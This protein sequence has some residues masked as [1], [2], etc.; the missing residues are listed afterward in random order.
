MFSTGQRIGGKYEIERVLGEGGM[1]VVVAA[2]HTGLG[3]RV[4]LKFLKPELLSHEVIV[5]RFKREARAASRIESD[6][7]ARVMDV[8]TTP[9]GV[10]FMVME[11]LEG[12]D[13]SAVRRR[14]APLDVGDAARVIMDACEAI[15]EAHRLGIVHRDIKPANIFLARRADGRTRVKVLDFGISKMTGDGEM[16]V[17]KTSSFMGSAEYM[18]PEQMLGTRDV[19]ARTDVWALGVTL[20]ELVTASVPF[21]ADS[22]PRVC[23][24]VLA[25]APVV[26]SSVRPSIPPALDAIILRCLEKE[27]ENRYAS[28]AE[29][30]AALAPFAGGVRASFVPDALAA[31]PRPPAVSDS[32]S[33]TEVIGTIMAGPAPGLTTAAVSTTSARASGSLWSKVAIGLSIAAV[34]G[35]AG[36]FIYSRTLPS[37][38]PARSAT[39]ATPPPPVERQPTVTSPVPAVAAPTPAAVAPAPTA[40]E[41]MPPPPATPSSA[42]AS[43][44]PS[45][46]KSTASRE[47][48]SKPR[49]APAPVPVT[50]PPAPNCNP[51]YTVDA[52]GIKRAKPQCL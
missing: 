35:A 40:S 34:V 31:A 3:Q 52:S 12:S 20:F 19:D 9:D 49:P 45:A 14:G 2:R 13:F 6:H 42:I 28:V 36:V 5:E 22:I 27:R 30:A 17:T 29:L 18:S 23:A 47:P 44:A 32:A 16:N 37:S 24:M 11:L 33:K 51:P 25:Q 1:G 43:G 8:D 39:T 48:T 46:V 15:G 26:P 50:L 41:T 10:P 21:P 38:P 7:V 4:A